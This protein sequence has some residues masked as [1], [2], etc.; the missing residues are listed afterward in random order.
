MAKGATYDEIACAIARILHDACHRPAQFAVRIYAD[1]R[2]PRVPPVASSNMRHDA[3]RCATGKD[4][5]VYGLAIGILRDV[6]QHRH[7]VP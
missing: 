5:A 2:T 4:L 3:G 6:D 1:D 7:F